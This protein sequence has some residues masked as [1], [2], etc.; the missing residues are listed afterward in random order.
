LYVYYV[1]FFF[2]SV[3]TILT[4]PDPPVSLFSAS[5]YRFIATE[6][7]KLLDPP[8][9]RSA[10]PRDKT[11]VAARFMLL[12]M[13][14]PASNRLTSPSVLPASAN[15][16]FPRREATASGLVN[17]SQRLNVHRKDYFSTVIDSTAWRRRT[18]A[19]AR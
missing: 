11:M 8:P 17:A 1:H 18:S 19:C 2:N 10:F 3:S 4:I 13:N 6:W 7:A 15:P 9:L 16:S 14:K 5:T 12:G